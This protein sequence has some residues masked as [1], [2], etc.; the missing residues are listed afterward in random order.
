MG[1]GSRD[2]R[3]FHESAHE[4]AAVGS[5]YEE[6]DGYVGV[7]PCVGDALDTRDGSRYAFFNIEEVVV[8]AAALGGG[9][10]VHD[11]SDELRP[12]RKLEVSGAHVPVGAAHPW[13]LEGGKESSSG[14]E[15]GEVGL[16]GALPVVEL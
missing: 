13:P 10:G 9:G 3:G 14:F 11:S 16:G 6:A 1:E 8:V 7:G 12:A 5:A 15:D 2:P 4:A